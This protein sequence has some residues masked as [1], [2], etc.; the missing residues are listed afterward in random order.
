M[1]ADHFNLK[2]KSNKIEDFNA[3]E[4]AALPVVVG[5]YVKSLRANYDEVIRAQTLAQPRH[6]TDALAFASRAWVARCRH[7]VTRRC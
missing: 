5:P 6:V 4:I 1:L 2:L 7:R 3:A